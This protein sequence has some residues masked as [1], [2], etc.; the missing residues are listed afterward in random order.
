MSNH[1]NLLYQNYHSGFNSKISGINV[2]VLRSL[3]KHYDLKILP[4]IKSLARNSNFLEFGCGPDYYL[5]YL[6]LKGINN[7]R[8]LFYQK[9]KMR[10]INAPNKNI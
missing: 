5:D 9:S 2:K 1:L 3:F 7:I 4:F 10:L 8:R 6:Q